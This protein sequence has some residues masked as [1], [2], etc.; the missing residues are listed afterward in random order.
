MSGG[1]NAAI[2]STVEAQA[3]STPSH[4]QPSNQDQQ[5][6]K[7][8]AELRAQ[9]ARLQSAVDRQRQPPPSTMAMPAQPPAAG[10]KK[11]EMMNMSPGGMSMG[12]MD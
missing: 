4:A 11:M 1:S 9:I 5:L 8:L 10:M 6:A 12:D 3:A 2:P 7:P